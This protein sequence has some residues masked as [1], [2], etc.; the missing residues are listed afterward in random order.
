MSYQENGIWVYLVTSAGSYVAY[1]VIMLARIGST[2]VVNVPCVSILLWTVGA[3]MVG[4]IVVDSFAP[5]DSRRSDVRDKDIHRFGE[6]T[7]C[8]FLYG[9]GRP[10]C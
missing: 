9:G 4:R 10:G 1:V 6:P 7:S 3:S 8:W 5:G 2:P